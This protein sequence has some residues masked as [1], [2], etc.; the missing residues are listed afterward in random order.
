MYTILIK[1]FNL[2][3]LNKIVLVMK[4]FHLI[5]NLVSYFYHP[6]SRIILEHENYTGSYYFKTA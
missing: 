1:H 3:K 5:F 6:L 2:K 4:C